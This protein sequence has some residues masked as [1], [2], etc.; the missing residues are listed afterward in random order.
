MTTKKNTTRQ[1]VCIICGKRV[2][3]KTPT[4]E[5]KWQPSQVDDEGL[6]CADCFVFHRSD[7]GKNSSRTKT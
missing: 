2:S 1:S 5:I 3:I 4:G 6:Y 7:K